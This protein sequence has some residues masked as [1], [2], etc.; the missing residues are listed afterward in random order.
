MEK[1]VLINGKKHSKLSVFNRL[2]QFGDGL[3]ETCVVKESQL[4]FWSAHF[5]RLEKG[6]VQLKINKISEKQW[7]QDIVKALSI[8]KLKHAI[9]KIILSRGQSERGYGFE[10]NIIPTRII[11]VSNMPE[12][13]PSEYMLSICRSG[14]ANN[15]LLS[16]IKHCNR[17]EQILA[18][19]DMSG[20]ECIMLDNQRNVISLTQGNIFAI[21]G[22]MLITPDLNNCGI[23]GTR[24]AVVLKIATELD[25]QVK[26]STLTLETL[27]NCE[28]VFITNSVIGIKPVTFI[29]KK[30]FKQQT[31]TKKL[32]Q[33]LN[34]KISK[35]ENNFLLLTN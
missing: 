4:L 15:S 20:D 16:N 12:K 9:V 13:I 1:I 26:V 21:S 7:L 35:K 32:A 10:K 19:I 6:R 11:I 17:L 22:K 3:F 14:Y 33:A 25:L 5:A 27:Y 28:E 8:A 23:Q 29:D 34:K 31:I 2:T 24:R 18:R 30:H